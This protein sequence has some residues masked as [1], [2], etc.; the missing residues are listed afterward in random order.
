M[1][2][3]SLIVGVVLLG[4]GVLT[5]VWISEPQPKPVQVEQMGADTICVE[6]GVLESVCTRCHPGLIANFKASGDQNRLKL[7]LVISRRHASA[8]PSAWLILSLTRS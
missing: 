3:K 1:S 5:G 7:R 2:W 6:H 4:A 8:A